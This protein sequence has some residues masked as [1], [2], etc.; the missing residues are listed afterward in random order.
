MSQTDGLV[1]QDGN[2][3]VAAIGA[4][5]AGWEEDEE[6]EDATGQSLV[7]LARPSES[8][9][10]LFCG[11]VANKIFS[12]SAFL[13]V[14]IGWLGCCCCTFWRNAVLPNRPSPSHGSRRPPARP[15]GGPALIAACHDVCRPVR[16]CS[17]D[18]QNAS[19]LPRRMCSQSSHGRRLRPEGRVHQ[20]LGIHKLI[21]Q[22][23]LPNKKGL[24]WKNR[25][26][27]KRRL[28]E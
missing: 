6:E 20:S 19:A 1:W 28:R 3:D 17:L 8:S 22:A 23:Q 2:R 16:G 27:V 18:S 12:K 21:S 11:S 26:S 14:H 9:L 5:G 15:P 7:S 4:C 25:I 10:C 24:G 13:Q